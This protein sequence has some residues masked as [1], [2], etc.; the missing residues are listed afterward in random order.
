MSHILSTTRHNQAG[1]HATTLAHEAGY[2]GSD[3]ASTNNM[4]VTV[5][6][7]LLQAVQVCL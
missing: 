1:I 6:Q 2:A 4:L 3:A 7:A 5:T